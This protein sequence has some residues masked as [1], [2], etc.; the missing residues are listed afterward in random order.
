MAFDSGVKQGVAQAFTSAQNACKNRRCVLVNERNLTTL[1]PEGGGFGIEF[2]QCNR[3]GTPWESALDVARPAARGALPNALLNCR[4]AIIREL[5]PEL[6]SAFEATIAQLLVG[7]SRC[8]AE[9]LT[10]L[11]RDMA[12]DPTHIPRSTLNAALDRITGRIERGEAPHTR[13]TRFRIAWSARR[14]SL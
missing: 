4:I 14:A 1:N 13:S 9:R 3:G 6:M 11:L 2:S 12:N 8:D 5:P 10:Q 7:D